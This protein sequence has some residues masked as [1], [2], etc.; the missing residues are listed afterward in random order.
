MVLCDV[1]PEFSRTEE[2]IQSAVRYPSDLTDEEGEI[3]E[4]IINALESYTIGRPRKGDLRELLNAIFIWIKQVVPGGICQKT[5]LPTSSLITTMEEHRKARERKRRAECDDPCVAVGRAFRRSAARERRRRRN[6][7]P[8]NT[9]SS[10][11]GSPGAARGTRRN[12]CRMN[13][14]RRRLWPSPDFL[15]PKSDGPY[16]GFREK[17]RRS[18][19][20]G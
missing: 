16:F 1:I 11:C 14:G 7:R 13:V 3:L 5:S 15:H 12:G 19:I 10:H 8:C 2:T 6:A 18:G 9:A 20:S 17:W 4:P